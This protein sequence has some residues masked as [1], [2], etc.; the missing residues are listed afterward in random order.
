MQPVR[1]ADSLSK[2]D[3]LLDELTAY[4]K[5]LEMC[6]DVMVVG[7]VAGSHVIREASRMVVDGVGGCFGRS[8][9]NTDNAVLRRGRRENLI[10]SEVQGATNFL[11]TSSF[12]VE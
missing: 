9:V 1:A 12:P 4:A 7:G 11:N 3:K 10:P 6:A 2:G 8:K 5:H